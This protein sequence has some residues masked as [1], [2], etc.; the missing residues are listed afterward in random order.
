MTF[1]ERLR[2]NPIVAFFYWRSVRIFLFCAKYF[3]LQ[4]KIV[5][6]SFHGKGFCDDPKYIFQEL[7]KKNLPIKYI[8]LVKDLNTEMPSDIK[9]VV[10]NSWQATYHYLTAKIWID[11]AKS[12]KKPNKRTGQFYLQTWHGS[13]S[14]KMVEK[15]VENYLDRNYLK[16]SQEDSSKIDLMY[17]NNDFRINSFKKSFW[18]NGPVI[19]SDSPQL[20]VFFS[21]TSEIK[22]KIFLDFNLTPN[23]KVV[24]YAPT[25][26]N[27]FNLDIYRWDYQSIINTLNRKFQ[28]DFVF[29]IR[30][31]PNIERMAKNAFDNNNIFD[32]TKYP[33]VHELIASTDVMI[34][35][36]SGVA[37]DMIFAQ[38]P[39]F[40]FAK[41]Y[42]AYVQ[43]DRPLYFPVSELPFSIAKSVKELQDNILSFNNKDFDNKV[44]QFKKKIGFEDSGNGAKNIAKIV[45][46]H[47]VK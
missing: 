16:A 18:Y 44:E 9:K 39:V 43:N 11:N 46:E 14:N 10:I 40:I 35:D 41:D 5:F 31:H 17:A 19:K 26:R 23:K 8:W 2:V 7:T 45:L 42:D 30:L 47:L 25:F 38:K 34:T 24:L 29:F 36:F 1:R 6:N 27:D 22:K 4:K 12:D 32:V 20:S 33:D 3:P 37:Y 21:D 13:F 15:D 28:S